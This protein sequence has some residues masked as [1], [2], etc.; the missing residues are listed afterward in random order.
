M[1]S[2]DLSRVN[3]FKPCIF[4]HPNLF[5]YKKAFNLKIINPHLGTIKIQGGII[6]KP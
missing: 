4:V 6:W 5:R 3:G 2:L 1:N